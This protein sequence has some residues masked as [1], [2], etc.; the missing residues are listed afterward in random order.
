MLAALLV[1]ATLASGCGP[2]YITQT[3]VICEQTVRV[4]FAA[5]YP[6]A[7]ASVGVVGKFGRRWLALPLITEHFCSSTMQRRGLIAYV[8]RC[9]DPSGVI[10]SVGRRNRQAPTVAHIEVAG[11]VGTEN[12]GSNPTFPVPVVMVP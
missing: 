6:V 9:A 11:A 12:V 7:D 10:V 5:T 2:D 3:P 1:A 8:D 4:P